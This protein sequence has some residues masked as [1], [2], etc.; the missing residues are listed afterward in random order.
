MAEITAYG[1]PIIGSANESGTVT[2]PKNIGLTHQL[3]VQDSQPAIAVPC[4]EHHN[5]KE[6]AA[7]CKSLMELN[8]LYVPKH[9]DVPLV[10]SVNYSDYTYVA[11][12]TIGNI[13]GDNLLIVFDDDDDD[14]I[15]LQ[16]D[17]TQGARLDIN[18]TDD[19]VS[20]DEVLKIRLRGEH[21]TDT[22]DDNNIASNYAT[23]DSDPR[24]LVFQELR[25][26]MY[27]PSDDPTVKTP[28]LELNKV[29]KDEYLKRLIAFASK[30]KDGNATMRDE[31]QRVYQ[32]ILNFTS[33]YIKRLRELRDADDVDPKRKASFQQEI[34]KV[35]SMLLEG[36]GY[37]L[38]K[39]LLYNQDAF[40]D[41]IPD[42]AKTKTN[43]TN[44][45]EEYLQ[46]KADD[47]SKISG[48]EQMSLPDKVKAL[49]DIF[50]KLRS[51][52]GLKPRDRAQFTNEY[53]AAYRTELTA[54][55][56]AHGEGNED[57]RA[58]DFKALISSG[59]DKNITRKSIYYDSSFSGNK[60]VEQAKKE[61]D[62]ATEAVN[63]ATAGSR[64]QQINARKQ[65]LLN[66]KTAREQAQSASQSDKSITQLLAK[67]N[68]DKPVTAQIAASAKAMTAKTKRYYDKLE[69][70][71]SSNTDFSSK[72]KNKLIK[73]I[74]AKLLDE[75]VSKAIA[76]NHSPSR[77]ARKL[78]TAIEQDAKLA[79]VLGDNALNDI[80]SILQ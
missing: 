20:V 56:R 41:V 3:I 8:D 66:L 25:E 29:Q 2:I 71:K 64:Q 6:S 76:N 80:S 30:C 17:V 50:A 12:D 19:D 15:F 61:L 75:A 1:K 69:A 38:T 68:Y 62:E 37:P 79:G 9:N 23:G 45:V 47:I 63:K 31:N 40:P 55:V 78:V 21:L 36:M 39:E 14:D 32:G 65:A 26:G 18:I 67:A 5:G 24:S 60:A 46:S 51:V 52:P 74:Q 48:D 54:I 42:E 33:N 70:K 10:D 53:Y 35:Q 49:D 22:S 13:S 58:P 57:F 59:S 7:A 77:I 28:L 43:P 72:R 44:M 27:R 34:N 73:A 11:P 4:S 16:D